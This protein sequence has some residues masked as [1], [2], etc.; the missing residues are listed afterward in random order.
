MKKKWSILGFTLLCGGMIPIVA[1]SNTSCSTEYTQIYYNNYTIDQSIAQAVYRYTSKDAVNDGQWKVGVEYDCTF[2][3]I[4]A[5]ENKP[6][7]IGYVDGEGNATLQASFTINGEQKD[8]NDYLTIRISGG[9]HI[10]FTLKKSLTELGTMQW[11][12][13]NSSGQLQ[14]YIDKDEVSN[15]LNWS[16]LGFGGSFND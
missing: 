11:S 9:N 1:L 10:Y 4:N 16:Y 7:H 15:Q 5:Y 8:P 3:G 12:S 13:T 14:S 6:V 2:T